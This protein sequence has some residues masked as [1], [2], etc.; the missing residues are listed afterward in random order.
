MMSKGARYLGGYSEKALHANGESEGSGSSGR[1]ETEMTASEDSSAPVKKCISLNSDKHNAFGI[2]TQVI[3]VSN[4]T[5]F[6]KKDLIHKLTIELEQVR[7][8]QKRAGLQCKNGMTMSSSSDIIISSN[9]QRGFQNGNYKRPSDFAPAQAKKI[10][11]SGNKMRGWNRGTSGR[12]ETAKPVSV[13]SAGNA[14]L[15]K[16]CEALLKRLMSHQYGWVFNTPVDVVK[17]NIPDY[18][19][20]IK[21]PM[22]LGTVKS[23]LASGAY[24]T[25]LEFAADVRLTFNNAMTYNPSGN[26]VHVMADTLKKFFEARW[27]NIEKKLPATDPQPSTEKSESQHEMRSAKPVPPS[28]KRKV[29]SMH[30]EVVPESVKRVMTN[31]E[32]HKL[33][34]E[35]EST[36]GEMPV[37]II[38]FLREHCSDGKDSGEDEIEIDIDNLSDD[39]LF[40]L[41]KLLDDYFQEKIKNQEKAE[42]CEIEVR[43]CHNSL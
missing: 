30:S 37:H 14:V 20:V 43:I 23:K 13:P 19:N 28:K 41:R 32:K 42:P 6:E 31:E 25:P 7:A 3:S 34:Q 1:V 18:F 12:F 39:T 22:D 26:D 40:T 33:S 24:R 17:L 35:L 27:K 21:K 16:Q 38:D 8:F 15:M 11:S 5:R 2:P 36:L 29:S 10:N 4:I 9:G